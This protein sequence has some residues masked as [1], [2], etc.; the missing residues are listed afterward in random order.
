[1]KKSA[2]SVRTIRGV[3]LVAAAVALATP[4]LAITA[5]QFRNLS[6]SLDV[7]KAVRAEQLGITIVPGGTTAEPA[8]IRIPGTGVAGPPICGV[9]NGKF[10]CLSIVSVTCPSNIQ[11]VQEGTNAI[12]D[13]NTSCNPPTPDDEGYCDCD[14]DY[15]SCKP[16]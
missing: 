10:E 14:I 11:L 6:K 15:G 5:R 12:F 8:G 1:M 13:C 2:L 4:A 16:A 9:I 3:L 7:G